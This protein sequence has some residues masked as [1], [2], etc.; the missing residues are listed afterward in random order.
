MRN[1]T[2]D[3]I[4]VLTEQIHTILNSFSSSRSLLSSLVKRSRLILMVSQGTT[5]L[6]IA[7]T[8]GLHYI[9][10]A[11]WRNRFLKSLPTL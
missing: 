7:E 4:P 8:I 1:K 10:V 11:T 2:V 3:T 9:N 5:N 6:K